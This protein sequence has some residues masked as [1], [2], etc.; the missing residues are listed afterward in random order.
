MKNKNNHEFSFIPI[1]YVK[2]DFKHRYETPRQGVLAG[3]SISYIQLEEGNNFQQAIKELEGFDRIWVI[4]VFHLNENWKTM[5]N[6][7]RHLDKKVGV[8]ASRSPHRPNPIGIS[9]VKFEK[10]DGLKI[11]I[12]ESDILDGSPI[13]DI[14][15][16]L[17]YSDSFPESSTGWVRTDIDEKYI[18]DFLPAAADACDWLEKNAE[19]KLMNFARLQLEFKPSDNTRKRVSN[20]GAEFELAYRTWRINYT[21]DEHEKKVLVKNIHSG[22]TLKELS[23]PE[24]KYEDKALHKKF[25]K[26]PF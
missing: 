7:P 4:Y 23:F 11:F 14:K 5:V 15:P 21:V 2:S 19:I 17:P 13:L 22:Y 26:L 10:I 20:I 1:G 6:P 18:V 16:Y 8:F 9:C 3:D 24:D 12:S 25:N